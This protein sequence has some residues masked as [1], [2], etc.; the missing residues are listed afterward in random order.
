MATKKKTLLQPKRTAH[1]TL[2]TEEVAKKIVALVKEDR[3]MR[4]IAIDLKLNEGTLY[5]W[6]SENVLG[7]ADMIEKAELEAEL[8]RA[9][10]FSKELLGMENNENGF[11]NTRLLAIKQKESEYLR[12]NLINAK[13]MY[14]NR[15][16]QNTVIVLPTPILQ[17]IEGEVVKEVDK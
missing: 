3:S 17:G 6:K 11:K 2:L 14:D 10:D 13:R 4:D 5:S 1:K 9:K 15:S 7:F 16:I 8:K 12:S